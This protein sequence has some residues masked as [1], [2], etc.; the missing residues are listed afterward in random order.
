MNIMSDPPISTVVIRTICPNK[1]KSLPT[2]IVE[3]PVQETAEVITKSA[4]ITGIGSEEDE[5][6]GSDKR[7]VEMTIT[8]KTE[9]TKTVTGF[10]VKTL[11]KSI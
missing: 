3:S 11:F 10:R 4:S 6:M 1:D 8:I 5:E 9:I 2:S 7:P